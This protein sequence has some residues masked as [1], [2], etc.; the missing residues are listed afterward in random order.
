[1]T[2]LH[3]RA[4]SDS[5]LGQ[6]INMNVAEAGAILEC[7]EYLQGEALKNG[8]RMAAHLIGAASEDMKDRIWRIQH[9]QIPS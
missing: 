7:L 2:K 4:N 8:Y 6:T 9:K 3:A 5:G 1:M